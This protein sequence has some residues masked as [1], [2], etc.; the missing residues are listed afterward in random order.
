LP[1]R[2]ISKAARDAHCLFGV[3]I[4]D[5]EPIHIRYQRSAKQA[6]RPR[7]WVER[8]QNSSL[9]KW[10]F[11]ESEHSYWSVRVIPFIGIVLCEDENETSIYDNPAATINIGNHTVSLLSGERPDFLGWIVRLFRR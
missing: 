1:N 10:F 3:K 9:F 8:M 6:T 5:G 4:G 7:G 2:S 11:D